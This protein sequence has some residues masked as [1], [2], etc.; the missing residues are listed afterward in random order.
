MNEEEYAI[1]KNMNICFIS[2]KIISDLVFDFFYN[3]KKMISKV[4]FFLQTDKGE[5]CSRKRNSTK[6]KVVAYNEIADFLYSQFEKNDEI[7][8]QGFLE[9]DR[10]VIEKFWFVGETLKN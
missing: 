1:Y 8:I 4:E 5:K 7:K 10:V 9:K 2:G 3:S 6:V